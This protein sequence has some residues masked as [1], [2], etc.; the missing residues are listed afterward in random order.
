MRIATRNNRRDKSRLLVVRGGRQ[1]RLVGVQARGLLQS[2]EPS[3]LSVVGEPQQRG[4]K[5]SLAYD[6]TGCVSV[7]A[8]ARSP[9]FSADTLRSLCADLLGA[10]QWCAR[11]RF[12]ST[13]LLC[14]ARHAYVA[15]GRRLRLAFVPLDVA[16]FS[17]QEAPLSLLAHLDVLARRRLTE[18]SEELLVRELHA[19]VVQSCGIFSV[20]RLSAFV[21]LVCEGASNRE[22]EGFR[23]AGATYA[24]VHAGSGRSFAISAGRM[25]LVGR[26]PACDACLRS[27][28]NVSRR[29]ASVRCEDDAVLIRDEGSTN[30]TYVRGRR[31][32]THSQETLCLG[33]RFGIAS[34]TFW[35]ERR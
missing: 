16:G 11:N 17:V 8:H 25:Q 15:D 33:E 14:G 12:P 10:T 9:D 24:L 1:E 6:I 3:L 13:G 23:P 18:P 20:N 5:T 22:C 4:G 26:D 29:H 31:L 28:R 21:R 35:V 19:L 32:E 7:R 30:G 2:C 34:E 27:W